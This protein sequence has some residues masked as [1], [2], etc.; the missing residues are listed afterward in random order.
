MKKVLLTIFLFEAL[1]NAIAQVPSYVPNNGLI[2][3]WPFS[4][5]ANDLSGNGN[6]GTVS[7]ATLINDR[8]STPNSA[9]SFD[10]IND[11]IQCSK[12]GPIGQTNFSISFWLSTSMKVNTS[13]NEGVG[14]IIG[15][16]GEYNGA[17]IVISANGSAH[18]NGCNQGLTLDNYGGALVKTDNFNNTWNF[19]VIVNDF[20]FGQN[21]INQ[22]IYKN[23]VL[24]I[25]NC[26]TSGIN[27]PATNIKSDFPIRIG[28]YFGSNNSIKPYFLEGSLDDIGIWNRALSQN[29][30]TK[31]Y[32]GCNKTITQQPP[33]QGMFTGNAIFT[34]ATND[35]LVNY[36]WQSDLG[37]GWNNLSNAGQYSGTTSN[38]LQVSNVTSNNNN[39]KFRC[40]IKGN[41]LTDTTNEATLR[42]WGLGV[43]SNSIQTFKV[44]PNPTNGLITIENGDIAKMTGYSVAIYNSIGQQL[45]QSNINQQQFSIDILQWGG[46][47]FYFMELKDN[48]GNIVEVKKIVLQ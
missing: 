46:N 25:Q 40:I 29:E 16:G 35:T 43:E 8:N 19:Y 37:M 9:Y 33:N 48:N 20:N 4:G 28:K 13:F 34:C 3:W 27:S 38:S 24:M 45:F 44:Y 30:I 7:G 12:T 36:Q 42:V 6:N 32:I 26:W 14:H 21:V 47:G 18:N 1:L 39:Q 10:G 15:Y 41:C 17:G 23:G 11:Y 22:K 31:L 5:N 2:G